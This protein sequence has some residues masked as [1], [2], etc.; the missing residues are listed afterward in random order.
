MTYRYG[1]GGKK[2]LTGSK[3]FQPGRPL[4]PPV[5]IK[6]PVPEEDRNKPI[7]RQ[8]ELDQLQMRLKEA[9]GSS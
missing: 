5:P 8:L 7:Q 1:T 4:I 2:V 9:F 6:K 3:R